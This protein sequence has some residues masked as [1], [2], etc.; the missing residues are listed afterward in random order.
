[1]YDEYAHLAR[2][3][4][5][6]ARVVADRFHVV[7]Q[8]TEA[9]NRIR[10]AAMSRNDKDTLAYNFMKS[11][12]RLFLMRRGDMPDKYY[13]RKSDGVTWHYDELIRYCE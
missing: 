11:K 1:M 8:L 4:L 7:K 12:R 10:V 6:N 5:P 9:V 2:R 3:W 13:T